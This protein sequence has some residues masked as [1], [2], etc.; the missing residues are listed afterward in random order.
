M[1]VSFF[2]ARHLPLKATRNDSSTGIFIAIAGIAL[3]VIVM[4]ISVA[5]MT[6]FR[7]EIRQKVI[8]FDSQIS[9]GLAPASNSESSILVSHDDIA[10]LRD[11]LPSDVTFS[12]SG[13]Q[14]A[15]IKTPDNFSGSVIKGIDKDYDW[16]FIS[17]NLVEGVVPDYNADS[18]IYHIV[19]SRALSR[20]LSLEL[21]QKADTYFLGDG[22]YRIRRLKIVGIYDTHFSEY[23]R[24]MI[25]GSL[26]MLQQVADV[27]D[28]CATMIE[29]N[30]LPDDEAIDRAEET[31]TAT[32]LDRLY[33]GKS[34]RHYTVLNIHKTAALFFNWLALLDTNVKV[35]LTLMSL[36]A[37]LTLVSSLFIL[38]LRRV[39]MIGILKAVGASNRL[40]RTVFI[41]MSVRILAW[42][43]L[44]GNAV[45]LG[46][47]YLQQATGIVP[48]NPDAYYLDHVPVEIHWP[49]VLALN[50]G[51][52]I[53]SL[54]VLLIPSAIITTIPPSK[55]IRYE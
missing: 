3:S 24:N 27:P 49:T 6:G 7:T 8:G 9:I 28:T 42:G 46:L 50:A 12:L 44:A 26:A 30:G 45:G 19:I 54:L 53:L 52:I 36:L 1:S 29:I 32:Y 20:A 38:I 16:S 33:T 48:L 2:I 37:L 41:I 22:A 51:I 43:L 15:I 13:R 17:S 10:P 39:N 14:P 34:Q 35:I 31:I 4:L 5:V 40:I 21:G 47:L 55:A 23:D 11:V 18:T 25:F